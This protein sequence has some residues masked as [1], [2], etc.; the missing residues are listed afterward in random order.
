MYT[1]HTYAYAACFTTLPSSPPPSSSPS[2]LP[3]FSL[4]PFPPLQ[5]VLPVN[6]NRLIWNAQKI[7]H[8][9]TRGQTDLH[10]LKIV[11]GLHSHI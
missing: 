9:D 8:I 4:S 7:F 5:V 11:E 3:P 6:L 10:P 2:P 1:C